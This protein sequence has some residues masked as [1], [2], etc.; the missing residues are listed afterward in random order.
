MLRIITNS[1]NRETCRELF[2]NLKILPLYSQYMFSLLLFVVKKNTD[3]FKSNEEIHSINTRY[4]TNLH[5]PISNLVTFRKRAHC[6]GIRPLIIFHI[7]QKVC[8]MR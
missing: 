3:Q 1:G 2:K 5:P 4:N 7:I 6:F 8:L